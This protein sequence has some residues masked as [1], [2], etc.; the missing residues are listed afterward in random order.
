MEAV[1][2]VEDG[3][4]GYKVHFACIIVLTSDMDASYKCLFENVETVTTV[5]TQL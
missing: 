1:R 4:H 2:G 5:E 3:K